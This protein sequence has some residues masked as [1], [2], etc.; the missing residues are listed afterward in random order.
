[1]GGGGAR[2]MEGHADLHSVHPS[3]SSFPATRL[4]IE[5]SINLLQYSLAIILVAIILRVLQTAVITLIVV[6]SVLLFEKMIQFHNNH[7]A[8]Y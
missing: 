1:M 5:T 2:K 6:T 4:I 7:S 3:E 8:I